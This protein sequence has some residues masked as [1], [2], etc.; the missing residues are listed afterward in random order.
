VLALYL[1]FAKR[2]EHLRLH[3][4]HNAHALAKQFPKYPISVLYRVRDGKRPKYMPTLVYFTLKGIM[5]FADHNKQEANQL[6]GIN[7]EIKH[8]ISA[9]KL[10]AY[11]SAYKKVTDYGYDK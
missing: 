7:L 9:R 4:T 1:D 8:G 5:A 10:A 11:T 6:K 3:K 2:D